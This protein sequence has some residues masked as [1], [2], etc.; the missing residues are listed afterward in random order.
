M[1]MKFY[2][3]DIFL[4]NLL[5]LTCRL[6]ST[7]YVF[8]YIDRVQELRSELIIRIYGYIQTPTCVRWDKEYKRTGL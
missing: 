3:F 8:V 6:N 7:M 1:V 4:Q 5:I 2:N